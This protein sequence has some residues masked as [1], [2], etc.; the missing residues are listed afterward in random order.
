[1]SQPDGGLTDG[2]LLGGR[3]RYQQPREGYRTGI[4]PVLLAAA[5]PAQPG[6]RV[7]EAGT[8]A[9]AGLLC[10]TARVPGLITVGIE[11][12]PALAALANCNLSINGVANGCVQ[13]G[14]IEGFCSGVAFDHALANPPWHDARGPAS[15]HAM[16]DAAKRA[17]PGLLE[18]WAAAMAG[19]L[20]PGGSLT[21]LLPAEATARALAALDSAACGSPALLPLWP[22]A[23]RSARL[24]LVQ[25]TRGGRGGCR[26]LPGLVLHAGTGFTP[27]ARAVLWEGERIAWP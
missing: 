27:P 11:R 21:L 25:A 17:T 26:V 5:V 15:P 22:Q 18:R 23:G 13:V 3:V 20:R 9:G 16:R 4:E 12:D 8:G 14:D 10:L 24:V 2:T 1:M 6:E 7:L 19:V